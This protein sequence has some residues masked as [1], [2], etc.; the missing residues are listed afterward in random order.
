M[1]D[2][3]ISIMI[4]PASASSEEFGELMVSMVK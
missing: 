3:Q 1:T 4:K 2:K